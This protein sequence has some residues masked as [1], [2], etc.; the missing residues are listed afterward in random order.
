MPMASLIMRCWATDP[1]HRPDFDMI[2]EDINK[3]LSF[4]TTRESIALADLV[5]ANQ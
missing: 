2:M 5:A 3:E 1:K 4:Y